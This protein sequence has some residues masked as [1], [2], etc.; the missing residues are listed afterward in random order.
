MQY[1]P[2]VFL[3]E[4]QIVEGIVSSLSEDDR[5]VIRTFKFE[6]LIGIHHTTGRAIRNDYRLWHP[7]NPHT[8]VFD[9]FHDNH[10]DQMSMRIIERVWRTV[11]EVTQ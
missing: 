4:T 2:L 8:V 1:E 10:P 6:G 3:S 11:N 7:D 9:S 5:N